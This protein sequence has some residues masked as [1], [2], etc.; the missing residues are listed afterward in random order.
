[1]WV[2]IHRKLFNFSIPAGNKIKVLVIWV[3]WI[4]KLILF[5][6]LNLNKNQLT[7]ISLSYQ[8]QIWQRFNVDVLFGPWNGLMLI[9]AIIL[10]SITFMFTIVISDDKCHYSIKACPVSINILIRWLIPPKWGDP[11]PCFKPAGGKLI[12]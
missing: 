12:E 10:T 8:N 5:L 7:V 1:M 9:K 4:D 6:Y 11:S 2:S 3:F